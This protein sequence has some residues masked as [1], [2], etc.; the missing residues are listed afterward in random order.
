MADK[1]RELEP[2]RSEQMK[3]RDPKCLKVNNARVVP[4]PDCS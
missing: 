3:P 1:G 4:D 2:D